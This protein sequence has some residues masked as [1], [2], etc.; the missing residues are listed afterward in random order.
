MLNLGKL[1]DR[2]D[3]LERFNKCSSF[4]QSHLR[5]LVTKIDYSKRV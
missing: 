5:Q 2:I 4:R 3:G 1:E